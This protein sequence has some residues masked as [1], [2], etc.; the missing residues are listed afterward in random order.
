MMRMTWFL[1]WNYHS[2]DTRYSVHL[3]VIRLVKG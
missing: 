1:Y 3:T 2:M